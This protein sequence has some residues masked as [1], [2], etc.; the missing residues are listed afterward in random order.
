[1]T[2]VPLTMTTMN[3]NEYMHNAY[4]KPEHSG[5]MSIQYRTIGWCTLFLMYG[6][7]LLLAVRCTVCD[8]LNNGSSG[9]AEALCLLFRL[10]DP[11]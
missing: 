1:M 10:V 5:S 8:S 2:H 9:L 7:T 6:A 4:I 11:V 3:H